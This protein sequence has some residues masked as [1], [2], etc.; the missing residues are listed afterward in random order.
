MKITL[1]PLVEGSDLYLNFSSYKGLDH[2]SDQSI[3]PVVRFSP[4]MDSFTDIKEL[5]SIAALKTLVYAF[6][7]GLTP[8]EGDPDLR[9]DPGVAS[10]TGPQYTGFDLRALLVFADDI[11][12]DMVGGSS[13]NLLNVLN[14]RAQDALSNNRFIVTVDGEI[15]PDSQFQYG[16]HYNMGDI[17][18][19]QGNSGIIQ[20]ARITEYIRTQDN[21]GSRAYPTVTVIG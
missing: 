2:T 17:I 20:T 12:T 19:V 1:E 6:A 18:E 10:L 3:N 9:T 14:S 4:T 7:P 16:I 8:A 11:T 13:D 5:Q 15:V 21:S